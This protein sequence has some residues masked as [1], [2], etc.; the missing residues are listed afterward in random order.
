MTYRC[1]VIAPNGGREWHEIDAQDMRHCM[2]ILQHKGF[3][4]LDIRMGAA[5][6]L[7][8]LQQ[9]VIFKR[10][11]RL[12]EQALFIQQLSGLIGAGL[13]VSPALDLLLE[14][15]NGKG[16]A[17]IITNIRA[18]IRE[19]Q[20]LGKAMEAEAFLPLWATG[21]IGA[22]EVSGHLDKA[23]VNI[24]RQITQ[25]AETRQKLVTSLTYPV[26]VL[27][28]TFVAMILVLTLI[29]PQFKSIFS[30]AGDDLPLLTKWVLALSY[31]I[32]GVEFWLVLLLAAFL[33]VAIVAH[34]RMTG[35]A[36]GERHAFIAK[37]PFV[38]LYDH[39]VAG[40]LCQLLG[41]LL[42]NGVTLIRALPL[43]RQT[44]KN[45]IWRYSLTQVEGRVREGQ[46]LSQ[47]L[48][49][50]EIFPA[51]AIRLIAVGEKTGQLASC[52]HQAGN[53]L[54]GSVRAKVERM[55]ALANPVATIFLGVVIALMVAG[56][57]LGIFSMGDFMG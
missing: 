52:C 8:K 14:T 54:S 11:M 49:Q 53:I 18:K 23:L 5:T 21:A 17:Q 47:S 43:A 9:P 51:T 24:A 16:T 41:A 19:G 40:Q 48:I 6:L 42:E 28:A 25:M 34:L 22:A 57:M 20:G 12:A 4:A 2:T 3:V 15:A 31:A 35:K 55:V 45:P 46:S 32:R 13:A 10:T 38:T 39:Y 37:L 44:M 30:G 29:V 33:L 26:A 56:V 7:E 27:L 50:A 1:L 36:K